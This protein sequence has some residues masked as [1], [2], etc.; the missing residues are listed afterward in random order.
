M[1]KTKAKSVVDTAVV[2]NATTAV[3]D[4]TDEKKNE[5][6]NT[7]AIPLVDTDEITVKALVPNVS[8]LDKR[9][10]DFYHWDSV[11]DAEVLTF[12]TLK[13]MWRNN[14]GYF[15]N[16]WLKP[17]D[18]RVVNRF[19]LEK[20]YSNYDYLM[21]ASNYTRTNLKTVIETISK[22]PNELK[23]SIVDRVKQMVS[24]GELTDAFIIREIEKRFNVDLMK[25]L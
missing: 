3:V 17:M 18:D 8:Y 9:T 15:R 4:V 21:S 20:T 23:Y 2:E 5:H 13:N 24:E 19:A 1:A 25:L 10:G 16:M 22:T 6:K 14:K 12:E 11:G 7:N